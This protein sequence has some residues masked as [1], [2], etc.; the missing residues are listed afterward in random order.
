MSNGVEGEDDGPG[1]AVADAADHAQDRTDGSEQ[2][3][4][5]NGTGDNA[6]LRREIDEP[7]SVTSALGAG[8][9]A[10][11][12]CFAPDAGCL[13]G[14]SSFHECGDWGGGSGQATADE[15]GERPIWTGQSLGA[16]DLEV[17]TAVSRA[18]LIAVVGAADA[19]KTSALATYFLAMRRGHLPGGLRFAGSYTLLGWHAVARHLGFPPSGSRGFPPHTTSSAGRS[20][21]LLHLRLATASDDLV[22]LLLTDVPGEWFEEWAYDSSTAAGAGWIADRADVFALLSDSV[23]LG[24]PDRGVACS[25]YGTLAAR[26]SS[27]AHRRPVIPLRAKADVAVPDE[28]LVRLEE[29]DRRSFGRTAAP[30]SVITEGAEPPDIAVL[31]DL[32]RTALAP[33]NLATPDRRRFGDPFL[34]LVSS[35]MATA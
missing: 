29:I 18:R 25:N 7:D 4:T 22:D 31:D 6:D 14:N 13:D 8:T 30:L 32:V 21:A 28:M 27:V 12:H 9:C 5:A 3:S 15:S 16:V 33:R 34:D 17:V 20:P 1:E 24:G 26:V 19:G 11:R 2:P 10:R 23:A 35:E